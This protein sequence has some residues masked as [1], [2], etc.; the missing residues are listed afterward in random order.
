MGRLRLPENYV[1]VTSGKPL[2]QAVPECVCRRVSS[3]ASVDLPINVCHVPFDGVRTEAE[4]A[5]NLTIRFPGGE[6]TD[7]VEFPPAEVAGRLTGLAGRDL[8]QDCLGRFDPFAEKVDQHPDNL[9]RGLEEQMRL[10]AFQ[11]DEP[12]PW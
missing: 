3:A 8:P 7:D 10:R 11:D 1:G 6:Q 9:L 12:A 5:G 4:T 2:R